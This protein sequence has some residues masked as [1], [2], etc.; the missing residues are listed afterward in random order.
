MTQ[1][2]TQGMKTDR[3]G[4]TDLLEISDLLLR[5]QTFRFRVAS[6]SM[7][8]ALLKG[9]QLT[10]EPATPAQ[11][12]VGDLLLF[13][14]RGRLICHRL[15]ATQESGTGPRLITKGDAVTGCDAPLQPENVLGRVVGVRRRWHWAGSLSQRI[16]CWLARLWDK[17]ARGLLALQGLRAYRRMMRAL[18]SRCVAYSV[19][20]PE[21]RRWFRYHRIGGRGIPEFLKSHQRFHLVA[22]LA[23]ICVGSLHVEGGADGFWLQALYVRIP[24]RG[25]GVGSQLLALAATAASRSR[26]P[27]LLAMVE[28]ANTAALHLF[29]KMGFR[30]M[31]AL[32]GNGV[33]PRRDLPGP[34]FAVLE[35]AL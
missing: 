4:L 5:G 25:L 26:P 18:L 3:L 20:I 33:S 30:K 22:R 11:L 1:G 24:Y 29:T 31:D 32:G 12:Q 7:A 35:R 28:P 19:A 17:V 10:V 9:D 34:T 2:I 14:D 15:V 21:G 13:H 8:P 23:G 6:W 16:D 27:V